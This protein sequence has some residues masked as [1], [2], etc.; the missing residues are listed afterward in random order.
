MAWLAFHGLPPHLRTEHTC[1]SAVKRFGG[2][3]RFDDAPP[4]L[5]YDGL[6]V[7]QAWVTRIEDVPRRIIARESTSFG[8]LDWYL[9]VQILAYEPAGDGDDATLLHTE[10]LCEITLSISSA[11][12]TPTSKARNI[13][14]ALSYSI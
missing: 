3:V 1:K 14:L 2:L 7:L 10:V 8:H 11:V 9:D 6:L 12:A 5:P 4:A 13:G